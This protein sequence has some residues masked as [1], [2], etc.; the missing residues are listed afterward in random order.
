[1]S[2]VTGRLSVRV[3]AV[4]LG[5]ALAIAV[6]AAPASAATTGLTLTALSWSAPQVDATAGTAT[7]TLT[8]SVTDT[9]TAV[10]FQDGSLQVA[11]RTPTGFQAA[12][13]RV[14]FA[15]QAT[16]TGNVATLVPGSTF[17]RS[18][19][20][21][22]LP[23]PRFGPTATTEWAVRSLTVSDNEAGV[24]L[25]DADLSSTPYQSGFTATTVPDTESPALGAVSLTGPNSVFSNG[26]S[27]ADLSYSVHV[28][29]AQSGA[30]QITMTLLGPGGATHTTTTP[31][32]QLMAGAPD[33]N[34]GDLTVR[35]ALD[36]FHDPLGLWT[37]Q[38]LQITDLDGNSATYGGLSVAPFT[39]THDSV[40]QATG[41][42]LSPNPVNDWASAQ[43]V[44]LSM[45]VTAPVPLASAVLDT[46]PGCVAGTPVL[47]DQ[48]TGTLTIPISVAEATARCQLS[49]LTLTDAAGDVSVYG[50]E[51]AGSPTLPA[52][53]GLT[54]PGPS[55][56]SG[57]VSTAP[58]DWATGGVVTVTMHVSS[59]GPGVTSVVAFVSRGATSN[60]SDP[61]TGTV[62]EPRLENGTVTVPVTLP[63]S[64][65]LGA[66]AVR[67]ELRDAANDDTSVLLGS[68]NVTGSNGVS[69][70]VPEQHPV[71]VLDTRTTTG[72]HHGALGAGGQLALHVGAPANATAAV[73]N[74]TA[75]GSTA[76]GYLIAWPDGKPRPNVSN[77]N[78]AKGQTV[79]NLVTVPLGPGGVVDIY[80]LA[81]STD[82]VAD[83]F[84][85]YAPDADAG[86]EPAA[87]WRALDTRSGIGAAMAPVQAGHPIE[88][89][90]PVPF[91]VD[92]A[93]TVVNVTVTGASTGGVLSVTGSPATSNLNFTKGETVANLAVVPG[94]TMEIANSTG[95]VEVIADV[96]GYYSAD[97]WNVFVPADPVRVLDTRTGTGAPHA[98]LGP[99]GWLDLQ[100]AGTHG[101][102]A[103]AAAAAL[104]LTAVGSTTG[105][106]LT[107]W[108]DTTP[109]PTTSS[110]NFAAGQ[111]AANLTMTGLGP[112]GGLDIGNLAGSVNVVGDLFGYFLPSRQGS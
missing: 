112:Q 50:P 34:D 38:Q 43:E 99:D 23:V 104:N 15:Q 86:Y 71:R 16:V 90:L 42:Q 85:Y 35:T 93:A 3:L 13:Y 11:M 58:I 9:D 82:V 12:S 103:N 8:F 87:P 74:L 48:T 14:G 89:A 69:A 47:P 88:V 24:A 65:R 63:P 95:S 17:A 106:Y 73:L 72:G 75:T 41:I 49:G 7:E 105:G 19:Y 45:S 81:G 26:A 61:V 21:F 36:P 1:M 100:V 84:G 37:V 67:A 83:L 25:A 80:N 94:T 68:I 98:P 60:T 33:V 56:L 6:A 39:W 101:I 27:Q 51:F 91:G 79:A 32:P 97:Y 10:E 111:T 44:D 46:A 108:P 29:D 31:A 53:T 96:V 78:F 77:V 54:G 102:P 22:T 5:S 62:T 76:G 52:V 20:T 64:M 18:T 107:T 92:V 66:H 110:V 28:S 59:W 55:V 4:G 30:S 70:F 40:V 57:T 2:R 109:R